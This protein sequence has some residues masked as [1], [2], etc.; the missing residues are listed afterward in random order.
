[1]CFQYIPLRD[2]NG[3]APTKLKIYMAQSIGVV[4]IPTRYESLVDSV[5]SDQ[6]SHVLIES[7]EDI[8]ALKQSLV[9][10][11]SSGQ[12]KLLFLIGKT[13]KGKTTLAHCSLI[14]LSSVVSGVVTPPPDYEVSLNDLPGWLHKNIPAN[15]VDG[16]TVVNMDGREIP[17]L[18]ENSRQAAMV[19]LNAYLR[20]TKNVLVVWPVINRPFADE[21]V[22]VLKQVGGNSALVKSPIYAVKGLPEERYFD[23][24]QLLLNTAGTRLDDAA[25]TRTEAEALIPSSQSLGDYLWRI[26]QL[27]VSRYDIGELG[28][29][30]PKISIVV[31][32]NGDSIDACRML[33]RGNK[34]LADPERLLQFSRANVADDW[35]KAG[36]RNARHSLPFIASLF[37]AKLVHLSGS[38]VVNACAFSDFQPLRDLVRVHYP[39][40]VRQNAANTFSGSSLVRS[41]RSVEDVG[42]AG[43]NVSVAVSAAYA[44]I[45]ERSKDWHAHIN[46]SIVKVLTDQLAIDLPSLQFE[47]RPHQKEELRVDC[48]FERGERPETL[49]F[50]H[51]QAAELST[52]T[53]SSYTLSKIMDYARDYSL[54]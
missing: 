42:P 12:A 37:E 46:R 52:A 11:T 1:M 49:E 31:T 9:E 23:A 25:I 20:R 15:R 13:G 43:G 14:Y 51:R 39:N 5:G 50:T 45:Q 30:L 17:A 41:L 47:Y 35:R 28:L 7:P 40:P 32:S 33:R 26:Q 44:K 27:V 18:D 29:S 53:I 54:T 19:N 48:W 10:V 3:V 22:G 2:L 4:V 8:A 38:M 6:V 24:L 34:F 21:L 16:I 36:T